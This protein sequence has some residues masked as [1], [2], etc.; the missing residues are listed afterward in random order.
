M[1][2]SPGGPNVPVKW[3]WPDPDAPLLGVPTPFYSRNWEDK[4]EKFDPLGEQ[5]GKRP[6]LPG[7]RSHLLNGER[8]CRPITYLMFGFDPGQVLNGKVTKDGVPLCC[9]DKDAVGFQRGGKSPSGSGS[10]F[11]FGGLTLSGQSRW[12]KGPW[13][14]VGMSLCFAG[15]ATWGPVT[16]VVPLHKQTIIPNP[17]PGV[18]A[19]GAFL[20]QPWC[21]R[22]DVVGQAPGAGGGGST[23]GAS[24]ASAA[25]GGSCGA[26]RRQ[27]WLGA[28]GS[29]LFTWQIGGYGIGGAPGGG[30]GQPGTGHTIFNGPT[31]LDAA[32]GLGGQGCPAVPPIVGGVTI[33]G[34]VAPPGGNPG[35]PGI[36]VSG[37][38]GLSP[39]SGAGACSTVGGAGSPRTTQGPGM[40]A[41]TGTGSGGSG[42]VSLAV[43]QPGGKGA[44]GSI[45]VDEWSF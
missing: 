39:A 2:F 43:S 11:G 33:A 13:P 37:S 34:G 29:Q 19:V 18:T 8:L 27:E 40:D 1:V 6:W 24:T 44:D 31:V 26:T 35:L 23:G 12:V 30:P 14:T 41:T 25:G 4:S 5:A 17:T 42:A 21:A 9:F 16:V 10:W 45:V 7:L 38:S 28:L 36:I 3:F 15:S 22:L 32:P 20:T